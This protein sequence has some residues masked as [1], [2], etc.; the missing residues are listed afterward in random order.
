MCIFKKLVRFIATGLVCTAMMCGSVIGDV[1]ELTLDA[2]PVGI[3]PVEAQ[4]MDDFVRF[5]RVNA[6]SLPTAVLGTTALCP[7]PME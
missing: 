7:G 3:I 4:N 5:I 2:G 6:T 1:F